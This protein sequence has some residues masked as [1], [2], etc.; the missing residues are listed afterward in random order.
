MRSLSVANGHVLL[1]AR[2]MLRN[3][4]SGPGR[5]TN[6][7]DIETLDLLQEVLDGYDGTVLLVSHDGIF[8]DRVATTTVVM[9]GQGGRPSMQGAGRTCCRNGAYPHRGPATRP[10]RRDSHRIAG[11]V[12]ET[13]A[14]PAVGA[15]RGTRKGGLSFT[16]K[17]RFEALP[18]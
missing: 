12:A 14:E 13:A 6:D 18:A 1:L 2:L 7:L 11:T 16:E 15:A 9:E 17:H 10:F 4:T 8:I 5:T 3:R